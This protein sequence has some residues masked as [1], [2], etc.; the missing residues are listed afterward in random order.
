MRILTRIAVPLLA[1]FFP[2][3]GSADNG[4]PNQ[5]SGV[6]QE[7]TTNEVGVV[8]AFYR[9]DEKVLVKVVPKR[10]GRNVV[11]YLYL[12]GQQ[13]FTYKYGPMGTEFRS[14]DNTRKFAKRPYT[15]KMAGDKES[16]INRITLYTDDFAETLDGYWLKNNA[17]IPWS[18]EELAKWRAFRDPTPRRSQERTR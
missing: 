15:I 6:R 14:A 17:V 8:T 12:D 13:V 4:E 3:R 5:V 2:L 10:T 1:V 16:R 9:G 18:A 7:V 11:Y